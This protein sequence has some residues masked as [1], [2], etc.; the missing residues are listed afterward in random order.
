MKL[1]LW[2]KQFL[3]FGIVGVAATSMFV[4]SAFVLLN[5]FGMT[6]LAANI[7]GYIFSTF[8]SYFGS[9]LWSFESRG[10]I[11]S[12]LKFLALSLTALASTI[13]IAEWVTGNGFPAYY[14]I[15]IT[16]S[17]IPI[18]SFSVQKLWVFQ[19]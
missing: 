14:G 2:Q 10:E 17:F 19:K 18:I 8:V 3:R 13:L 4:T 7:G 15:L 16:A 6:L 5:G 12:L 1:S 9:A 11:G